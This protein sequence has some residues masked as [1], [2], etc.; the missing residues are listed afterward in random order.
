MVCNCIVWIVCCS[1]PPSSI[2]LVWWVVIT[3]A[4]NPELTLNCLASFGTMHDVRV[5]LL[6]CDACIATMANGTPGNKN[7]QQDVED[8]MIWPATFIC[9]VGHI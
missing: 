8:V 7:G 9:S 3:T 5:H 4:G 6:T 1:A 2:L